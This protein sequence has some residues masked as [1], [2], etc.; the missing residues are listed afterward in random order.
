MLLNGE[1]RLIYGRVD[2]MDDPQ[3]RGIGTRKQVE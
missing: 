1:L 3:N 2:R